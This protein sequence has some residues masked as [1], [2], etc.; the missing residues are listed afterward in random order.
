M[1]IGIVQNSAAWEDPDNSTQQIRTLLKDVLSGTQKVDWLIL[2]EMALTGFTMDVGKATLREQDLQFFRQLAGTC[3]A[4]VTFG[5]VQEGTNRSITIAP[6]G[7]IVSSYAKAHLF[8]FAHEDQCY[9]PG[10]LPDTFGLREWRITPA[11]CY[12]LR[13][14]Y[15]F[16]N[17]AKETD[18]YVVIA[19]WPSTRVQHWRTLLQARAIENQCYMIGVNRAGSDPHVPYPGSS[20]VVD[21]AGTVLFEGGSS[22]GLSIVPLEKAVVQD[23]RTRFRFLADRY[24]TAQAFPPIGR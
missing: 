2:P 12:D 20:L 23:I 15:L 7:R 18:A 10:S 3:S 24:P 14:A 5:A 11:V 8:S 22:E 1:N 19:N 6:E 9:R 4:Y 13:F 21:P 17:R 16:W